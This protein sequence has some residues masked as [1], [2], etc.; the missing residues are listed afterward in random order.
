MKSYGQFC[1]VAKAAEL[2]CERWTALIL[3]DLA[4]GATQFSQLQRGVP[5]CSPS[6]LS[7]RL[8]ALE[9]EGVIERRR[10]GSGRNWAYHLTEAGKDFA[11]LIHALGVWG[12][13]WTR[14]ELAD[15]EVN[16][17]LLIWGLEVSVRPEAFGDRR[18]VVQ[19]TF[20]D[21][22]DGV[23]DWWFINENRRAEICLEAPGFDVDLYLVTTLRDMIHIYRGDL[24]LARA[25]AEG[26]LET[27]GAAWARRAL[28]SWLARGGWA[29][30]KSLRP[31]ARAAASA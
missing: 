11:P 10:A 28:P 8:K 20:S 19:L 3:R 24:A 22:P 26:R 25:L 14:R 23:Q 5:L 15:H 31:E 17:T 13:R 1:P 29:Q 7:R 27:H 2:F 21:Q 4:A 30:V 16:L 9:A 18:A 12:Q 6:L